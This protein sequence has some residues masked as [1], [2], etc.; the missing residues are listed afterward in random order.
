MNPPVYGGVINRVA[1]LRHHL[2]QVPIAQLAPEVS[3]VPT[4]AQQD[5]RGLV[6]AVLEQCGLAYEPS[7]DC[8][9][10]VAW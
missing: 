3:E 8:G 4:N 2:F 1:P 10:H 6:M 5:D 7:T 9:P